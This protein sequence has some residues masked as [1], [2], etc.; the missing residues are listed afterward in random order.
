MMPQSNN[1]TIIID[2]QHDFCPGGALA[3]QD[4][5]QVVAPCNQLIAASSLCVLTQDWHPAGHSSFAS[6]HEA[7]PFTTTQMAYGPQTLWPEH[8]VQGTKGAAFHAD[9][10]TDPAQLILR[11]GMNT[12][13]DSYSAFFE[14]DQ[15]SSTGLAGWLRAHAVTH[16]TM[17]GLATDFC[18]AWSALDARKE[19]FDVSLIL[20]ACR[21]SD[22]YGSLD[23]A[24]HAMQQA[25]IHIQESLTL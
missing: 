6:T 7:E 14:N 5:D 10:N 24:L 20:P 11:K 1:A 19:G 2:V 22:L 8:C 9:L 15:T 18:V 16:L 13:I 25:G 3:V 12:A 4:G 17:A 21:A 23:Q